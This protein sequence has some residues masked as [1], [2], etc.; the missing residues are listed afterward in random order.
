MRAGGGIPR[1]A[2]G[3]FMRKLIAQLMRR[4]YEAKKPRSVGSHGKQPTT[5]TS[6]SE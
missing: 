6:Q 4:L 5:P 2:A 1:A 3:S